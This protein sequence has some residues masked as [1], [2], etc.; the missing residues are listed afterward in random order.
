[1]TRV[2]LLAVLL[3]LCV[4]CGVQPSGVIPGDPAPTGPVNGVTLYFVRN[5]EVVPTLRA[6]DTALNPTETM[7]LLLTGGVDNQESATGLTTDLPPGA[8]PATLTNDATG[9]TLTIAVDPGPLRP[10]AK[11]QLVCT[12]QSALAQEFAT[13]IGLVIVGPDE[14]IGP[15]SRCPVTS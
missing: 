2:V 8:G 12:A 13:T 6:T 11:N 3:G 4:G 14:R 15:M 9:A 10:A 1:M 7:N 5:G